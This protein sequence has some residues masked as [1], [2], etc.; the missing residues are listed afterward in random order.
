[1]RLSA[2][3]FKFGRGLGVYE[4]W[5]DRSYFSVTK[6][7]YL[8]VFRNFSSICGSVMM[9]LVVYPVIY[10]FFLR[11]SYPEK[12]IIVGYVT[13]LIMCISNPNFFS[14][15][16]YDDSGYDDSRCPPGEYLDA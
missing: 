16:G 8:E 2:S 10:A 5:T 11:R 12:G 1:M 15:I 3:V 7:T 14:S 4:H 9:F 13:Y 6:L